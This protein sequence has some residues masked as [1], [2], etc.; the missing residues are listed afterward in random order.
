MRL[1]IKSFPKAINALWYILAPA[2]GAFSFWIV[3]ERTWGTWIAGKHRLEWLLG[4]GHKQLFL[5]GA[6]SLLASGIWL[7][8]V[9]ELVASQDFEL[10]KPDRMRYY[11]LLGA[12]LLCVL[13]LDR[14]I[15]EMK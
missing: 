14:L 5:A 12:V 4:E 7:V 11:I 9:S 13:P 8:T 3:Y 15:L 10:Q 2:T 1:V 6:F